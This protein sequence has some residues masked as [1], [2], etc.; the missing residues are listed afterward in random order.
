MRRELP[1]V[2]AMNEE[3]CTNCHQCIAVCPVKFC[4]D[5]S[6][7]TVRLN[8]NMCIGCG[9]CIEA[10][11][12]AHNG[13]EH[14]AARTYID[15]S[16]AMIK[17][18][19]SGNL[20]ALVAPSAQSNFD[21]PRLIT[22]LKKLGFQYIYDVS[23][24]AEITV[25][26]YY[27]LLQNES[28]KKPVIAQPCPAIV[29]YI[30]LQ[31]PILIP[32]LAPVGSPVHNIAVY[33]KAQYPKSKLVFISPCL[34]KSREFSDSKII[35]YNVTF[36]SINRML[37]Q[38][39]ININSLEAGDFDNDIPA[40]IAANFSTP[41]GLKES[42]THH[43]PHIPPQAITKVEGKIVYD[44]YLADLEMA[45]KNNSPNLPMVVDILNCEK[46]CNM[47]PGCCNHHKS[48]DEIETAIAAKVSQNLTSV[49]QEQLNEFLTT[50]DIDKYQYRFYEDLTSNYN[51]KMPSERELNGINLS[52]LKKEEKDYRN[53]G[54][55]GYNSCHK[56]AVAIFNGL[57]KPENCHLYQE[58]AL[59]LDHERFQM[60]AHSVT[61]AFSK[62]Q[63]SVDE[64]SDHAGTTL[65]NF[66]EIIEVI[67]AFQQ[68]AAAVAGKADNLSPIVKTISKIAGETNMLALNAAIE[69][70]HA[71]ENG[72]GF[73]VV[74]NE[75]K[76]LAEST[77]QELNKVQPVVAEMIELA[78][79][80]ISEL[81]R[82]KQK[83]QEANVVINTMKASVTMM[84]SIMHEI[85]DEVSE[86]K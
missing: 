7:T 70:A 72:R 12:T 81:A 67:D 52:M 63:G 2:I 26:G 33:V 28:T 80:Q 39:H 41:G 56:M 79:T 23:L 49:N 24:G 61:A 34:A 74:A 32:H 21:L 83:S 17:E 62:V 65:N 50:T 22:A 43:Y 78:D 69:A 15:D 16:P 18:L 35:D 85:A 10:C 59:G 14:K 19:G 51:I 55:C 76:K 44:K 40:G 30:E 8:H 84:N 60:I 20:I 46:G 38:N 48:I 57:N 25:V 29:K 3:N 53:C 66:A 54:A 82:I 71:G 6:G 9:H 4:N 77:K 73:A 45:I 11:I 36:Q 64:L 27:Q 37:I 75:V 42:F 47:G 1:K 68:L 5:G 86:I 13:V 58:K 31:Y